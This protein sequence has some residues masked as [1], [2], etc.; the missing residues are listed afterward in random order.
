MA[1]SDILLLVIY[2]DPEHSGLPAEALRMGMG[3]NGEKRAVE[4]VLMG[5]AIKVLTDQVDE[6]VDGEMIENHLDVY[7]EWGTPFHV[8]AD[9]VGDYDIDDAPVPVTELDA[10]GLASAMAAAGRVMVF[11]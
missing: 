1:D 4:I 11:R 8:A 2:G 5:P 10:A 7:E 9:A 6:L 3:L